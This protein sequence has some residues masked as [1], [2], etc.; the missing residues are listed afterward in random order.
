MRL[1]HGWWL[2]CAL[3]LP[4]GAWAHHSVVATYD[5][6]KSISISG[7][8]LSLELANPHSYLVVDVPEPGGTVTRMRGEMAPVA[9]LRRAGWTANTLAVGEHVQLTGSPARDSATAF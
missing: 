2:C 3:T 6:S 7:D 8:V 4:T 5:T 9:V 1:Q